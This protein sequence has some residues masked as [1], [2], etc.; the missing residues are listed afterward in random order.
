MSAALFT[1]NDTF[2][3]HLLGNG[4]PV[5]SIIDG[6]TA[7]GTSLFYENGE[8]TLS[9]LD[10]GAD[11]TIECPLGPAR[12]LGLLAVRP[13]GTNMLT[14]SKRMIELGATSANDCASHYLLYRRA[15]IEGIIDVAEL[16]VSHDAETSSMNGGLLKELLARNSHESISGIK[17]LIHS[18]SKP[19]V[20]R[21]E[22]AYHILCSVDENIRDD[23]L[24]LGILQALLQKFPSLDM[25]DVTNKRG[26]T[27]LMCAVIEGNHYALNALLRSGASLNIGSCSPKLEALSRLITPKIFTSSFRGLSNRHR[28]SRRY[29][30]NSVRIMIILLKHECQ[31]PMVS[32]KM[33]RELIE[34]ALPSWRSLD[35]TLS[36]TADALPQDILREG[37]IVT[38]ADDVVCLQEKDGSHRPLKEQIHIGGEKL[39][40]SVGMGMWNGV[41]KNW[42]EMIEQA[43]K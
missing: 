3:N 27:A 28:R 35:F 5:N 37:D 21:R 24:N 4:Y 36:Y 9:L 23:T 26:E 39:I 22:T 41:V 16:L 7:L 32:N 15:V 30:D 42:K 20:S 25:L 38:V 19:H 14:I 29:E 10:H 13:V 1:G 34:R 40:E 8:I 33:A 18:V 17:Y 12:P 6:M 43:S 11:P 2:V 31:T